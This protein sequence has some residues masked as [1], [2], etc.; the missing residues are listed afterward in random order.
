MFPQQNGTAGASLQ[1]SANGRV[2]IARVPAV[3]KAFKLIETI[4]LS[5]RPLGV[6]ELSRRLSM[7][8]STVHGLVTTLE[9]LGV[10]E[11]VN[12]SKR[13]VLGP[14]LAALCSR[15]E[16]QTD[17]RQVA[18]SALERLAAATEQTSFFGVPTDGHVTILDIVHGRPTLSISAPVGSSI[19]LLAGAVGKV[20]LASWDAQRRTTFL[21]ENV[22]PAFTPHSIVRTDAY[23]GA[24]AITQSRGAATD[25]DEYVD[26]VR[27]AAAPVTGTGHKLIGVLWVAG[28]SRNIDDARL[29]EI[30]TALVNEASEI[31]SRLGA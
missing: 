29:D 1:S 8:K 10:V 25:I 27:A 16:N 7:G 19:P 2:R 20:V 6:S 22:L 24:V 17:L 14:R 26:G 31:S 11:A 9:S 4:S 13:Y 3:L 5:D 23:E 21:R 15:S 18:H 12:G 30:A 28:F